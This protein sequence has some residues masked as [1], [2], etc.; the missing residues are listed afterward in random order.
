[1]SET[2]DDMRAALDKALLNCVY[3]TMVDEE[4][5]VELVDGWTDTSVM[6]TKVLESL[7][8]AGWTFNINE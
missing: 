5:H 7:I 1:M 8:N 2:E 4:G 3:F 6:T